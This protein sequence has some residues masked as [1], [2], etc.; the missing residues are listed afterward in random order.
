[1]AVVI[2]LEAL[3]LVASDVPAVVSYRDASGRIL[4]WPF[5]AEVADGRVV[6]TADRTSRKAAHLR[7]DPEV[8][9]LFLDRDDPNRYLS[10]SGRVVGIGD[11]PDLVLIDRLSMRYQRRPYEIRDVEREVYLVEPS[12]ATYAPGARG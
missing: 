1:M 2:P 10:I 7:R 5:W 12:R 9:I 4:S 8:G 3:D 6:I 11:D